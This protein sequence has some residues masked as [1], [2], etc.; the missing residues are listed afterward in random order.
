VVGLDE[1]TL[2]TLLQLEMELIVSLALPLLVVLIYKEKVV[3]E[4]LVLLAVIV[5]V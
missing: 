4:R 5:I 1:P 2:E 3:V